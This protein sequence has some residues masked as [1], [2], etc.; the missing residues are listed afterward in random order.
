MNIFLSVPCFINLNSLPSVRYDYMYCSQ[1]MQI[2]EAADGKRNIK[3]T[4]RSIVA[5]WNRFSRIPV[6]FTEPG[7]FNISISHPFLLHYKSPLP[8]NFWSTLFAFYVLLIQSRCCRSKSR[9]GKMFL[10]P[11]SDHPRG[12][13]KANQN[14]WTWNEWPLKICSTMADANMTVC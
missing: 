8:S 12:K 14:L 6:K 2:R 3:E 13:G 7:F 4:S 10:L 1:L 9:K 5:T 11:F